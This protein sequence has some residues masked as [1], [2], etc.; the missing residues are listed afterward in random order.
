MFFVIFDDE[1]IRPCLECQ[2]RKEKKKTRSQYAYESTCRCL[3]VTVTVV[4]AVAGVDYIAVFVVVKFS[5]IFSLLRNVF[6]PF[7][8]PS[9]IRGRNRGT[10]DEGKNERICIVLLKSRQKNSSDDRFPRYV[11]ENKRNN[12]SIVVLEPPG[13]GRDNVAFVASSVSLFFLFFCSRC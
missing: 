1:V 7:P 12:V 11:C 6:P 10:S 9:I 13:H 5:V 2:K 4:V 3:D 8:L